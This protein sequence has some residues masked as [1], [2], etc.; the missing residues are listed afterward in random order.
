[1]CGSKIC[2]KCGIEK[3]LIEFGKSKETKDG[4]KGS[5]KS[6]RNLSERNRLSDPQKREHTN[7]IT[8]LNRKNKKEIYKAISDRYLKSHKEERREY[9]RK[10]WNNRRKNDPIFRIKQNI[11]RS[12]RYYIT[13][14]CKGRETLLDKLGYSLQQLKE[15]LENQ[16]DSNM[17]WN[18]YG[19]YWQIDHIIP[20]STFIY[21]SMDD[22]EFKKCWSLENLRPLEATENKI[23]SN[24]IIS[25]IK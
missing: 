5:C 21:S 24:K 4:Y 1:M 12:I 20:H 19:T 9:N 3:Q 14:G 25:H 2:N 11:S 7:R 15:H 16:F 18:N 13:N 8:R 6:C 17:N 10:Y 22:E 23:K